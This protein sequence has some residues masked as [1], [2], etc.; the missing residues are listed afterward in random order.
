MGRGALVISESVSPQSLSTANAAAYLWRY[1]S[2]PQSVSMTKYQV[3]ADYTGGCP[4]SHVYTASRLTV[5]YAI[6]Y[7]Q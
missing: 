4:S 2:K 7:L 6:I 3:H 1:T 5:R